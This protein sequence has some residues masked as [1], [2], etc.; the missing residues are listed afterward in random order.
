M[1]RGVEGEGGVVPQVRR[2]REGVVRIDAGLDGH[3]ESELRS[4]CM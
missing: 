3:C 2:S 1:E 4:E